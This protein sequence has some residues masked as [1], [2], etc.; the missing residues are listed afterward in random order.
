[1]KS[2]PW[3]VLTAVLF[4]VAFA[5]S[6][7]A[8]EFLVKARTT[9]SPKTCPEA[10]GTVVVA[11][12]VSTADGVSWV[13]DLHPERQ[14][15]SPGYHSHGYLVQVDDRVALLQV[16]QEGADTYQGTT[17]DETMLKNLEAALSR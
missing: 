1:M 2:L 8:A 6:R 12:G 16:G 17:G 14:P 3:L 11:Q 5:D 9:V 10:V 13:T 4:G 7:A 15:G